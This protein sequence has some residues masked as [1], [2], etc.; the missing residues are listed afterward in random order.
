MKPVNVVVKITILLIFTMLF[1]IV[2]SCLYRAF[3]GTGVFSTVVFIAISIVLNVLLLGSAIVLLHLNL[4][5]LY[6][7]RK[8]ELLSSI[9]LI[10][11][12]IE[13][14]TKSI[15]S[16]DNMIYMLDVTETKGSVY[17]VTLDKQLE[18]LIVLLDGLLKLEE[19]IGIEDK[20]PN[21][22]D[23]DHAFDKFCDLNFTMYILTQTINSDYENIAHEILQLKNVN[24]LVMSNL[25]KML[26]VLKSSMPILSD[27]AKKTDEYTLEIIQK[28]FSEFE[29]V[30][31]FSNNIE[32]STQKT[33]S[34]FMNITN[35]DS[36]AY[37]SK[38][39]KLIKEQFE[40]FYKSM[41]DLQGVSDM[42]LTNSVNSLKGIEQTATTIEEISEKIKLISINVRIEAAHL[43]NKN[44][45]FKVLGKD[46]S[47]FA[48]L[49]AK[50]AKETHDTINNTIENIEE[51]KNK[52]IEQ[53]LLVN[54]RIDSMSQTIEPFQGIIENSFDKFKSVVGDLNQFSTN[55]AN[56]IKQT[57]GKLQYHDVTSQ[58]S[59]HVIQYITN[60]SSL[61]YNI[62]KDIEIESSLLPEEKQ[63]IN[64][65]II[66]KI[67]NM[68]TTD[69]EK[70]VIRKYA[71]E[72]GVQIAEDFVTDELDDSEFSEGTIIF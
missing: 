51:L 54:K 52:Y 37:I 25:G 7:S 17:F 8:K 10:K 33:I 36:L 6:K 48:T 29:E 16:I 68:I 55:I 43:D 5:K 24:D 47:N 3:C 28:I 61:Y 56:K 35:K 38:E 53:M 19:L 21:F 30:S 4:N 64:E 58:E 39:T 50:I 62:T 14:I 49:T 27:I 69:N 12:L 22:I 44:S 34:D 41:Q 63:H 23:I 20:N 65:Y 11:S 60:I 1:N 2:F 40:D 42:F 9:R 45:G 67:D 13:I 31:V 66:D 57:I 70:Q 46:I 32:K 26:Y 59:S 71:E 15:Q 72:F 18:E